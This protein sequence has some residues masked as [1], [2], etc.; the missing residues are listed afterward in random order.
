[1]LGNRGLFGLQIPESY[2]GLGLNH[3]DTVAILQQLS[4]IDV[5]LATLVFLHNTNGLR[6]IL[7]FGSEEMKSQL[8]PGLAAGR[9][10]AAFALSEPVAGSNIGAIQTKAIRE[11]K[12]G[13][14]LSGE[15][16]WNGSSW[17]GVVTVIA[18]EYDADGTSHGVSAFLVR[19]GTPG[20]KVGEESLTLGMRAIVQNSLQLDHVSADPASQLGTTGGGWKV[21]NDALS[22]GRLM[23]AAVCLGGT[24]RA[25]QLLFRYA[26][27]REIASGKLIDHPH[28][29]QRLAEITSQI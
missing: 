12:S 3:R 23:T 15:K 5:S 24:K 18:R 29:R 8:L 9:Q 6:P 25:A 7:N 21:V 4:A 20:L 1:D 28:T 26:G 11:A 10:L 13:W 16:R 22:V 19:Q 14:Q 17:A 2:G 27:V